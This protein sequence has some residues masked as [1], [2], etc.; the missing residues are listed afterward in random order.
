MGGRR[1]G[2]R[3]NAAPPLSR[4]KR[5]P[6]RWLSCP[7]CG[8]PITIPNN[9]NLIFLPMKS[10][11]PDA[12]SEA[13]GVVYGWTVSKAIDKAKSLISSPNPYFHAINV[14]HKN[15]II[16]EGDWS[17]FNIT[18]SRVPI[19]KEY[20]AESIEA[21]CQIIGDKLNKTT[22]G[23]LVC[24]LYC[25]SGLNRIGFCLSAILTK[26]YGFS[27]KE[28]LQICEES[29]PR[30]ICKQRPLDVLCDY[31]KE[32]IISRGPSPEWVKSD[33]KPGPIGDIPLPLE[34]FNILSKLSK[35]NFT[36]EEKYE[37]LKILDSVTSENWLKTEE[38]FP[39][40]NTTVWNSHSLNEIQTNP[41]LCTFEPR[42]DRLFLI[43]TGV[44]NVY[45]VEP[46]MIVTPIRV[47]AKCDF[48]VV[49]SCILIEEKKTRPVF[50]LTDIL[51]YGS[52]P[53]FQ[54][55]LK[56][57][58]S[59]LANEFALDTSE[60]KEFGVQ[61]IFRPMADVSNASKLR[62][63]L[64]S[65]FVKSDGISFFNCNEEAGKSLFLP[66]KPSFIFQ[67]VYNG[68]DRAVLYARNN[69]PVGIYK[70]PNSKYN[71][72]DER[73]NRFVYDTDKQEWVAISVGSNSLP[74]T[75]EEVKAVVAFQ[76][77]PPPIDEIFQKLDKI[78]YE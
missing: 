65:L 19:S 47:K 64:N 7:E 26:E 15:E 67:F 28:S 8:Q 36:L 50:L 32:G 16:S 29:S 25:G 48:P 78:S 72:M 30:L 40:L 22:D 55:P 35:K 68:N 10:P 62:R 60:L 39:V 14:S 43:V 3:G 21:F 61:F 38:S 53:T 2:R 20:K 49:V 76:K 73:T 33:T 17:E 58:L 52:V 77:N 46:S 66:I 54:L 59:Y 13:L 24:L 57:R 69:V 18:Y 11:L 37:V 34:K 42:G 71:G 45:I 5:I 23:T 4:A 70:S 1:L 74:S 9:P 63:D 6:T 44:S 56:E 27:L 75:I 31:F 41:F 51:L 12:Y